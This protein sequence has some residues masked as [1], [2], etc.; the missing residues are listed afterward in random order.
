MKFHLGQNE[1]YNPGVNISESPEALAAK[2]RSWGRSVLYVILLRGT[3][4][5]A[6]ILVEA[7]S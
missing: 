2:R 3:C 1:G 5:Q 6:C 4:R 7:Y